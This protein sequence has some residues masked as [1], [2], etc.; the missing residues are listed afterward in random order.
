MIIKEE[1]Y[2]GLPLLKSQKMCG[3]DTDI[4]DRIL[5]IFDYVDVIKGF[6]PVFMRFDFPASTSCESVRRFLKYV[7]DDH[8]GK[9]RLFFYMY[10]EEFEPREKYVHYHAFCIVNHREYSSA[11]SIENMLT[12]LWRHERKKRDDGASLFFTRFDPAKRWAK[13]QDKEKYRRFN[14]YSLSTDVQATEGDRERAFTAASYLAKTSQLPEKVPG[15]KK[16]H[17]N[18]SILKKLSQEEIRPGF[19]LEKAKR[20]MKAEPTL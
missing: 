17:W 7:K 1:Y 2:N 18:S 4:L 15:Q 5:Y 13:A 12:Y 8:T 10:T 6:S 16:R 9:A 20:F 3:F 11:N 14:F 19:D